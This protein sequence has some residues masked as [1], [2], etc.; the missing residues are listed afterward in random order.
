MPTPLTPLVLSDG[1]IVHVETFHTRAASQNDGAE[2]LGG[3]AGEPAG[4]IAA[5][6]KDTTRIVQRVL[7]EFKDV[8][9]QIEVKELEVEFSLSLSSEAGWFIGKA[10]GEASLTITAKLQKD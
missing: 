4:E 10:S 6:M 7:G 5:N 3:T 8:V 2:I 9:K 1:S